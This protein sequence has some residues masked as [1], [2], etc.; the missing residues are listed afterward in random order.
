MSSRSTSRRRMDSASL[1]E[2]RRCCRSRLQRSGVVK[3]M[4][5]MRLGLHPAL[6]LE[7]LAVALGAGP[8][9]APLLLAAPGGQRPQVLLHQRPQLGRVDPAHEHEGHVAHVGEAGPVQALHRRPAGSARPAPGRAGAGAGGRRSTGDRHL[10]QNTVCGS[11]RR[12]ATCSASCA[13]KAANTSAS[14]RGARHVQVGQLQQGLQVL[15]R[16]AAGQALFQLADVGADADHLA[17]SGPCAA[18]SGR[19]CRRRW[20]PTRSAAY[21]RRG[22]VAGRTPAS[23]PRA[24]GRSSGS[25]RS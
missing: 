13:L 21:R 18:R 7:A 12:R 15:G 11:A 20:H 10:S 8:D 24:T 19:S 23:G 4:A 9:V 16:G 14:A 3:L 22:V 2:S 25:R 1:S 6:R 17:R 5:T